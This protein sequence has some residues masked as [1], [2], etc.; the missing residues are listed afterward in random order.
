MVAGLQTT[1][2]GVGRVVILLGRLEMRAGV[3]RD[4]MR[5]QGS[6][7]RPRLLVLRIK[8][9]VH[10]GRK[11]DHVAGQPANQISGKGGRSAAARQNP[12]AICRRR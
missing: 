8:A 5:C 12:R 3:L 7:P 2:I 11:D 6:Q 10:A 4:Q 9:L 1:E